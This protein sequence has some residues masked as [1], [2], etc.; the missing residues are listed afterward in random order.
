MTHPLTEDEIAAITER[1]GWS[2]AAREACRAFERE[3]DVEVVSIEHHTT[4]VDRAEK[5]EADNAALRKTLAAL[6][7]V[8]EAGRKAVGELD[9]DCDWLAYQTLGMAIATYDRS[10]LTPDPETE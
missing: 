10:R 3:H 7:I 1:R 4:W 5:A 2:E 6:E 9:R 8:L